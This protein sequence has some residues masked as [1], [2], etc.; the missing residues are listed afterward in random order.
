MR[1]RTKSA[2]S[3]ATTHPTFGPAPTTL[4]PPPT[5]LLHPTLIE[6]MRLGSPSTAHMDLSTL[7]KHQTEN[8]I[9][10][11]F[12]GLQRASPFPKLPAYFVHQSEPGG[13]EVKGDLEPSSVKAGADM[14]V[15][16]PGTVRSHG[17]K[18]S[19]SGVS[20]VTPAGPSISTRGSNDES[21]QRHSKGENSIIVILL[22]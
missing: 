19:G 17:G 20:I 14:S 7:N 8:E 15:A 4:L 13:L 22:W 1:S 10:E 16:I 9:N 2:S 5:A 3:V 21:S 11:T 6:K 18:I 12:Y